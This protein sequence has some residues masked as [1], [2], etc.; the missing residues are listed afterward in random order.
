MTPRRSLPL[1]VAL[2]VLGSVL[3]PS[4]RASTAPSPTTPASTNPASTTPPSTSPPSTSLP[5]PLAAGDVVRFDFDGP[6]P[7]QDLT[8]HGH[9]LSPVSRHGGSFSTVAHGDGAALVFPP[10]CEHEPCP[11]I[12]LRSPTD[13]DLNPWK[14]NIRYGASVRLPADDTTKGENVLQK[15]YSASGSQYKLQIDGVA[16][17]PSCVMVD[18]TRPGIHV[19]KSD[20][21]VADGAWHA[22]ECR[23]TGPELAVL[24]DGVQHGS[25]TVPADL[26]V[27]NHIPLSVGGKGSFKDNDQFQ[28]MLDNVWVAIG[29]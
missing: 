14:R 4:A 1:L 27:H 2:L 5:P 10:P 20:L 23:R 25:A 24:V 18:D 19:A 28:G 16:G 11:R 13:A 6:N 15:G 8:G 29:P 17:H 7:L 22:L 12:A 3:G 26:T 21:S 9:D